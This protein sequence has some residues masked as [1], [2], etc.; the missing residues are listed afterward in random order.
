VAYSG[1][2]VLLWAHN[3]SQYIEVGYQTGL[4][5]ESTTNLIELRYKNKKH[6]DFIP[7]KDDGKL[8][9]EALHVVS[10]AGLQALKD[11][12][13]NQK[14]V[15]VQR[16]EAGGPTE[17]A[18]ALVESISVENPD[19]DAPTVSVELQLIGDWA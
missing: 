16:R 12:R 13:K 9:L 4:S 11:A 14:K 17:T 6:V 3:G 1:S 8:T 19:D 7:G 18:E 15:L 5:T 2:N 10:D